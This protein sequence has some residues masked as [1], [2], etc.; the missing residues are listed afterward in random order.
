MKGSLEIGRLV[1]PVQQD[2]YSCYATP[3]LSEYYVLII[4]RSVGL[5]FWSGRRPGEERETRVGK[6]FVAV[7]SVVGARPPPART[8]S[9]LDLSRS[10][11]FF[12]LP[13]MTCDDGDTNACSR[14]DI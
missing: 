10:I 4:S 14:V 12:S 7:L 9:G 13:Y 8:H 3:L 6:G 2:I 11:G 1:V 5:E